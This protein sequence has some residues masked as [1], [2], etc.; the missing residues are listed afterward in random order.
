LHAVI[1]IAKRKIKEIKRISKNLKGK[2]K[3]QILKTKVLLINSDITT[4]IFFT[5]VEVKIIKL[6]INT[7]AAV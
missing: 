5:A 6:Q 1:K 3:Q 4:I 7:H 2:E